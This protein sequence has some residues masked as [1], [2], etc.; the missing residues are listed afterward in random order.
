[1]RSW[2]TWERQSPDLCRCPA[3]GPAAPTAPAH[4]TP[5]SILQP[6]LCAPAAWNVL[7]MCILEEVMRTIASR[8]LIPGPWEANDSVSRFSGGPG[9]VPGGLAS[10]EEG[11]RIG[12]EPKIRKESTRSCWLLGGGRGGAWWGG[13]S[14]SSA[15]EPGRGPCARG[16]SRSPHRE[17]EQKPQ[18]RRAELWPRAAEFWGLTGCSRQGLVPCCVPITHICTW[19]MAAARCTL[20][21]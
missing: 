19:L 13:V 15:R 3:L 11:K 8:A 9:V 17:T 21:W 16:E 6:W 18:P 12:G 5:E 7:S 4:T 2:L 1:M 14:S 10:R 20:V